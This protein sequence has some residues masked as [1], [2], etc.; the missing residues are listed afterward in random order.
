MQIGRTPEGVLLHTLGRLLAPPF[1]SG[2]VHDAPLTVLRVLDV[3]SRAM[4]R[5]LALATLLLALAACASEPS[6]GNRGI[7]AG[8]RCDALSTRPCDPCPAGDVGIQACGPFGNGWGHC[9]CYDA[10]A[11][12]GAL[13]SLTA[14]DRP[15]APV[16]T[17]PA[18]F[19]DV[20]A[21][22][23]ELDARSDGGDAVA[24]GDAADVQRTD[25]GPADG[26]TDAAVAP[27]VPPG[28]VACVVDGAP[29]VV[30]PRTDWHHCGGCGHNCCGGFCINGR[31]TA[32]GPP[33]TLACPISP[34]EEEM[35]RCHSPIRVDSAF[36]RNHCGGCNVRCTA[37][38]ACVRGLCVRVATDAGADAAT[39]ARAD[40]GA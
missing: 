8:D 18:P 11:D 21:D 23:S 38:E 32:E 3:P 12:G 5:P 28:Y 37:D 2:S 40:L 4:R 20:P 30:D 17:E 35:R 6:S 36:D 9:R 16:G 33:G 22:R 25:M 24:A 10:G 34:A 1:G 29:I 19:V 26:G 15:D 7:D 27:D 13:D 31:C 14:V 39:D